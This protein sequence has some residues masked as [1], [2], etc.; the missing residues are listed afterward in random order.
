MSSFGAL[1]RFRSGYWIAFRNFIL[2]ER[3]DVGK[4]IEVIN[5]EIERI[6]LIRVQYQRETD[7]KTN[8]VQVTEHR[9]GFTVTDKSSLGKLI[10]A[11]VA[12][13]GNPFDISHFFM[14]DQ[15]EIIQAGGTN[16]QADNYPHGGVTAPQS[17]NY[18]EP[19]GTYHK[20]QGGFPAIKKYIGNRLD[21]RT[22]PSDD[23]NPVVDMM[24]SA[25]R[26]VNREIKYK[27]H[28]LEHRIIKLCDLREQLEQ[29][30]DDLLVQAHGGTLYM[31]PDFD[32]NR[33]VGSLRVQNIVALIDGIFFDAEED[34]TVNSMK[35]N[36]GKIAQYDS[37]YV[38]VAEEAYLSLM[39]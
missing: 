29:E 1:S 8:R 22:E 17:K 30:R 13:G 11:Y 21:D 32:E 10:Q 3:R 16:V 24:S 27:I 7:S 15:T 34:G 25:R 6:G 19:V 20:Y 37:F 9:T 35:A 18:N 26:W 36:Q 28:D 39:A 12:M 31:L 2:Q 5:A 38:D 14:P 23:T 33:F 4:R